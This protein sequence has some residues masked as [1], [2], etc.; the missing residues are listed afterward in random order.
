[1]VLL[2]CITTGT[3]LGERHVRGAL[4]RQ[5]HGNDPETIQQKYDRY[6]NTGKS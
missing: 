5:Q 2:L 3:R 1:M 6:K 4:L